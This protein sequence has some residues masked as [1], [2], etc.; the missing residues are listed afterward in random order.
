[1]EFFTIL[2]VGLR[3]A[4]GLIAFDYT[5]Q[6]HIWFPAMGFDWGG[7]SSSFFN[8]IFKYFLFYFLI[9][10]K[11]TILFTVYIYLYHWYN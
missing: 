5:F 4:I 3:A 8:I 7:Q 2:F 11:I 9:V 10:V 6:H 1:M